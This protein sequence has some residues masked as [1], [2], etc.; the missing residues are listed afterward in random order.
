MTLLTRR[1]IVG[2]KII[3]MWQLLCRPLGIFLVRPTGTWFDRTGAHELIRR[4]ARVV[5]ILLSEATNLA[6]I[7]LTRIGPTN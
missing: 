5:T 3:R 1:L 6:A 2:V 7:F 4:L